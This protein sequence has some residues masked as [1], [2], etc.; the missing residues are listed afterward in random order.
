MNGIERFSHETKP[1]VATQTDARIKAQKRSN[2]IERDW[3]K[4]PKLTKSSVSATCKTISH[5]NLILSTQKMS[6][7]LMAVCI[8]CELPLAAAHAAAHSTFFVC[9]SLIFGGVIN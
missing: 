9:H 8:V 2:R 3:L 6:N 7:L 4:R 5:E 1:P